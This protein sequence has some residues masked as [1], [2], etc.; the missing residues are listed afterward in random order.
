MTTFVDI[1]LYPRSRTNPQFRPDAIFEPGM[2]QNGFSSPSSLLHTS[3]VR[4]VWLGHYLSSRRSAQQRTN[5]HHT[6]LRVAAIRN[7]AG[8]MSTDPFREGMWELLA[9]SKEEP[10]RGALAIIC[11]ETLWWRYYWRMVADWLVLDGISVRYLSV[12]KG[13]AKER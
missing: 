5:S 1:R 13:E 2:L 10:I 12:D 9:L 11:S 4:Y 6:A 7:S 8:Y 3:D